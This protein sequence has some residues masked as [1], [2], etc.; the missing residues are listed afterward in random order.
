MIVYHQAFDL[1]HTAYRIIL[2]LSFLKKSKRGDVV[3]FDRLR[4]WDYY[5]L[6]PQKMIEISFNRQEADVKRIIK[7]YIAEK[8]ISTYEFVLDDK[9]MFNKMYHYQTLALKSLASYGIINIDYP[10]TK[11][12][13]LISDDIFK[14]SQEMLS[15]ISTKEQ[16]VLGLL[17]SH[18]YIMPLNG[19]NGLKNKTNLIESRYDA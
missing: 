13:S 15:E 9:K 3:E 17:T 5:L 4:I 2:L 19:V 11:K 1:Y 14:K 18:Y 6:F 7:Q 16:N 8:K 10:I 12:I